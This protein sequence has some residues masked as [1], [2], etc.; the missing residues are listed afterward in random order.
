MLRFFGPLL[1][2]SCTCYA[3]EDTARIVNSFI[4]IIA[5]GFLDFVHR[6][7]F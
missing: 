5:T 6:P 3:T 2:I 4:T 7:E 1:T